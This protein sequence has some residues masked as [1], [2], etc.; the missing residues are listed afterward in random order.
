MPNACLLE[1]AGECGGRLAPPVERN[2]QAIGPRTLQSTRQRRQLAYRTGNR[3][4]H[5]FGR[6]QRGDALRE[7][8]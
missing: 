4:G 5:R 3:S 6:N 8:A 1:G 2:D 7:G